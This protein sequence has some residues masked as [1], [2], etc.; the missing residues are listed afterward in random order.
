LLSTLLALPPLGLT[1]AFLSLVPAIA[2]GETFRWSI[3]WVPSL[4]VNLSFHV[5]GL[6]LLFALLICGIGT[7]IVLY[8]GGYLAGHPHIGRFYLFLLLFLG[9]MLGLVLADNLIALYVF[10]EL[11]SISSYLLIGFDHERSTAR[12]AALQAL[13][14][15]GAGG[16][17]MLGGLVLMALVGGSSEIS[18]LLE[19][20]TIIRG[21]ELYLP[22]LL[23]ILAAAFTK[24]AQI[25]FHS[26]LPGAMEAPTPVSAYLHSATMVKAGIYLL[27]R[28]T[29]ILGDTTAWISIV[30]IVGA[31]TMVVGGI[32]A[33]YQTDLKRLLAYSTVSALGTLTLL[34]GLGTTT[35]AMAAIVF[36]LA[37]ALYKGALFMVAGAIDHETGTRDVERLG[38]LWRAMPITAS[39]AILAAVS[40]AGAGPVLSFIGKEL[41]VEAVLE[42]QGIWRI[43]VPITVVAGALFVAVA[44][45]VSIRPFFGPLKHTP[46]H[47]HEAPPSLWLGPA[48]LSVT[49]LFIGLAPTAVAA[50][51]VSPAVAAVLG[52]P[53]P[54]KL[55]LWHGWN[56]ALALSATSI[57]IGLGLYAGWVA[58]RRTTDVI[59]RVL[60]T[61]L[62]G[63]YPVALTGLNVLATAQ[64]RFLQNGYLRNYLTTIALT[65]V[66]LAGFTLVAQGALRWAGAQTELRLYDG[67]LAVLIL[68]A[69]ISAVR[70]RSR[71]AAIVSLGVVGL[72]VTLIFVLYGAP[73][74][75]MTQVLI[76]T[77]SVILFLLVLYHLPRFAVFSSRPARIQDAV[78]ALSVGVLMT[79]LV[80]AATTEQFAPP[81]SGYF[82]EQSLPQAHGRNVVNVILVDFRALDTLGE[83]T[84]LALAGLGVYALL[85][86]R[87]RDP[88]RRIPPAYSENGPDYQPE[89]SGPPGELLTAPDQAVHETPR[90]REE[91]P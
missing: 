16:L 66:G 22:I 79:S 61:V 29:P 41:L 21:S 20:G 57:A 70:S 77:L 11:T 86:L 54:V 89:T 45:I 19:R 59:H 85:K 69:A 81:I 51:V 5:D 49:G 13:L 2:A 42:L 46:K 33:L 74:L 1:L 15:T 64:T 53:E 83:I 78:V 37:H 39:T 10:W 88:T 43:L 17:A 82:L 40:L 52:R 47:A 30:S 68:S 71:L 28:F 23:L 7:L 6:S 75:A 91:V 12:A 60:L 67:A 25:P 80:L 32:L 62:E 73:D 72:G 90:E 38:G 84:V 4:G 87:L 50:A 63:W 3:E 55:V 65:T 31:L 18:Q 14:I 76:E 26:W 9:A 36:L 24:S 35:S 8:A 27:A 48:L 44:A 56:A 58:L 34:L